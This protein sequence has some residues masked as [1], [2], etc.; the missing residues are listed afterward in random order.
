MRSNCCKKSLVFF[1]E[2]VFFLRCLYAQQ[3]NYFITNRN[4]YSQVRSR[5]NSNAMNTHLVGL[6]L[7]IFIDKQRLT[8]ENYFRTQPFTKFQRR[9]IFT[10]LIGEFYKI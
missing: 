6:F 2:S 1:R 3:T 5:R 7:N 9:Q 8:A 4:W 10:V